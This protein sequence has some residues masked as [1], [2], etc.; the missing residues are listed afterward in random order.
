[1]GGRGRG[2]TKGGPRGGCQRGSGSVPPFWMP[3]ASNHFDLMNIGQAVRAALDPFGVDVDISVETPAKKSKKSESA[4][5][6]N[7]DKAKEAMEDIATKAL[8]VHCPRKILI[9]KPMRLQK[10]LR[11]RIKQKMLLKGKPKQ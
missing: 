9:W 6:A 11:K 1:M 5:E 2:H 10:L 8:K 3:P 7:V 4:T